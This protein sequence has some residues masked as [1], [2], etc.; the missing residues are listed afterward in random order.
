M[1]NTLSAPSSLRAQ[2]RLVA[3]GAVAVL[4]TAC[5]AKREDAAADLYLGARAFGPLQWTH[6]DL[7]KD[8]KVIVDGNPGDT[9]AFKKHVQDLE[10]AI[11]ARDARLAKLTS[12]PQGGSAQPLLESCRKHLAEQKEV[13]TPEMKKIQDL[14]DKGEKGVLLKL[15]IFGSM[16]KCFTTE[17]DALKDLQQKLTAYEAEF[18]SDLK[19]KGVL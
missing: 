2:V 8:L 3:F 17:D 19:K 1:K 13:W 15:T 7:S 5:G 14:M 9:A 12:L 6:E 18:N 16:K 11:Q 4:L 10:N